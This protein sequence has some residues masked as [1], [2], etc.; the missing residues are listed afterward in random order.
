MDLANP[1]AHLATPTAHLATLQAQIYD[2]ITKS[3]EIQ[4]EL[5]PFIANG[6]P[7]S[8]NE[9]GIFVNISTLDPDKTR[10][11]H[12]KILAIEEYI[13]LRETQLNSCQVPPSEPISVPPEIRVPHRKPLMLTKTQ[14]HLLKF[15]LNTGPYS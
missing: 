12:T 9:N 8:E 6:Y 2:K 14:I 15:D 4:S 5:Y 10:T 11:L 7:H 13:V 3:P 1:T